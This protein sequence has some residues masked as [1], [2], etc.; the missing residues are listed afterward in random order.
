MFNLTKE[1]RLVLISLA[2]ICLFGV[3][4]HFTLKTF[5]G[6][7]H[8]INVMDSGRLYHRIDI[9][10]A[11]P[12]ELEKI[13]YIGP[14]IAERIIAYRRERGPFTE[15]AQIQS[16]KGINRTNYQTISKFIKVLPPKSSKAAD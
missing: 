16:V 3:T 14:A 15:I 12:Q 4:F 13:P 2:F 7:N 10:T 1:E 11:T 5:P 6:I 8:L 9:N